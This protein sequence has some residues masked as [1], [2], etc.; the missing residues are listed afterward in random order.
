MRIFL[1]PAVIAVFAYSTAISQDNELHAFELDHHGAYPLKDIT[2]SPLYANENISSEPTPQNEPTIRIS[3][4]N[5]DV[6]VAA[7][8]DF[9][10]GWQEPNVV[11]R[12]GY[13]YSHD[14]GI[15]WSES[16]LLPDPMPDHLSQSDPVLTSD[17]AGNFYLS[18][19]SRQPVV[20]YN[21]QM[22]LYKS[23]DNGISFQLHAIAVPGSGSQGEDKEWIFCDPVPENPTFDNIMIVWK[24]FGPVPK[25]KFSK[26][27]PGGDSWGPS[28]LVGDN[29][30][31]QGANVATGTN[32]S[33]YVVWWDTGVKFDRSTD[34]GETFGSDSYISTYSAQYNTS[35]PFICVDYS[36]GPHRGNVYVVWTDRRNGS[37][38]IWFQRSTDHGDTWMPQPIMVNDVAFNQQ[39]WP[40]IQ[41][42]ENGRIVVVYYDERE[43]P[44]QMNAYLAY[45]DDSGNSWSNTRLSDVTFSGNTPNTNVRFGDYI[46]IDTYNGKII[47]VWTDDRAG[48]YNQEV[49]TA[50]VEIPV[51]LAEKGVLNGSFTL[52]QNY[53]NP[54]SGSTTL[55]FETRERLLVSMQIFGTAGQLIDMPVD[56]VLD[57]GIHQYEW[58]GAGL[59]PGIYTLKVIAGNSVSYLKMSHQ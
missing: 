13:S 1:L 15:T 4:S 6:V 30:G 9:R 32:G 16:Q 27:G 51:A 52:Y 57:E 14:G 43:G 7:W 54:F 8:R 59:P 24:S 48:N 12:I 36:D 18:S 26:S 47:P 23:T 49:Y 42:D 35:F 53:P 58:T 39:Y 17:A 41:C 55:K 25:I 28:I 44:G 34:G 38:D 19:T 22:L 10:L 37:D 50:V 56:E 40:S 46:H 2:D 20:S 5:P 33:I 31:G 29:Y 3:R 45:S 11:R 21:R